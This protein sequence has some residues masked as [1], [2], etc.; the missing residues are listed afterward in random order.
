MPTA[1]SAGI[2]T[3][4]PDELL[5]FYGDALGL[6][7]ESSSEFPQGSIHRLRRGDARL[8]LYTPVDAVARTGRPDPWYRAAGFAYAALLLDDVEAAAA[9]VE[10]A[11][12]E[13]LVAPTSHRPGAVYALIADPQGNVWE[14]LQED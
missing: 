3:D 9:S 11:G 7:V 5:S 8:K 4:Q 6:E 1:L 13:I 2:V 12:G 14:L 10:R